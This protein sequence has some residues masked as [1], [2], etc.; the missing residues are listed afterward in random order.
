[1]GKESVQI[2]KHIDD[3]RKRF[4]LNIAKLVVS[5]GVLSI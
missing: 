4:D 1:M 3:E 2:R 5:M